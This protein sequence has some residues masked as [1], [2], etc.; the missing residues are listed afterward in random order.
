M[1]KTYLILD[2]NEPYQ[3]YFM[4]KNIEL[5]FIPHTGLELGFQT[6]SFA[7]KKV[8]YD[9]K[10]KEVYVW[11]EDWDA[12]DNKEFERWLSI[13]LWDGWEHIGGRSQKNELPRSQELLKHKSDTREG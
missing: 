1:Y 11:L 7:V 13:L 2:L 6:L 4:R 3:T 12:S 9:V 8:R 10:T 5:D